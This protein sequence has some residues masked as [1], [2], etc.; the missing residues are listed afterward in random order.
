MEIPC[1]ILEVLSIKSWNV[2]L[3]QW[4]NDAWN[5]QQKSWCCL[6]RPDLRP[7]VNNVQSLMWTKIKEYIYRKKIASFKN[8]PIPDSNMSA[9]IASVKSSRALKNAALRQAYQN[10]GS[11]LVTDHILALIRYLSTFSDTYTFPY[12][13]TFSDFRYRVFF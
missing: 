2:V 5:H 4:E 9:V 13:W 6:E 10:L 11:K 1:H 12:S 3:Y 8:P 7:Y